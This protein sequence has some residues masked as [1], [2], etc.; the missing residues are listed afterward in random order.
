MIYIFCY[1]ISNNKRRYR[2]SCLLEGFG[3]RIQESVFECSLS[4]SLLEQLVNKLT[5]IITNKDTLRI[6]PVCKDCYG[7]SIGIGEIKPN[8]FEKGYVVF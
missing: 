7:K 6:Y 2:T 8:I 5:K 3:I 4:I 1:D